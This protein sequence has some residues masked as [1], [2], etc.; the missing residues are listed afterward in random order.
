MLQ[1]KNQTPKLFIRKGSNPS[2][3]VLLTCDWNSK[4]VFLLEAKYT[5]ANSI[6]S[7]DATLY[8]IDGIDKRIQSVNAVFPQV[9]RRPIEW[10]MRRQRLSSLEITNEEE[11]EPIESLEN[12][13]NAL[14]VLTS[15][16]EDSLVQR[17]MQDNNI[18][19]SFPFL[20]RI[21]NKTLTST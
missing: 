13:P 1:L 21:Q 2:D 12:I 6:V 8:V 3:P 9:T 19:M 7:L 11:S 10:M 18:D 17:A 5:E 14:R 16:K 15:V 20:K 4:T